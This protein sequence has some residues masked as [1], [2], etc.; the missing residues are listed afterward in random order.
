MSSDFPTLEPLAQLRRAMQEQDHQRR[1]ERA[2]L[3][4][5]A[6]SEGTPLALVGPHPERGDPGTPSVSYR[7]DD[8]Q[9]IAVQEGRVELY[10]LPGHDY[11][12]R[13]TIT[14]GSGQPAC[15]ELTILQRRH[16]R[17][18]GGRGVRSMRSGEVVEVAL[19]HLSRGDVAMSQWSAREIL[20]PSPT[21]WRGRDPERSLAVVIEAC[22][23]A[24]EIG[25]VRLSAAGA[26]LAADGLPS[27]K[28]QAAKLIRRAIKSG[29][30]PPGRRGRPAKA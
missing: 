9:T 3:R 19:L 28:G 14:V 27:S 6:R 26:A 30:L 5:R 29:D 11:D 16:G 12:Y 8:G 21:P 18:I 23:Q 1:E 2:A 24:D 7:T 22:R 25:A 10:N 20:R 4:E 17:A 15:E 13:V